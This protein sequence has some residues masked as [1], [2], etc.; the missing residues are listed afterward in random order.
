MIDEFTRWGGRLLQLL[1]AHSEQWGYYQLIHLEGTPLVHIDNRMVI[2]MFGGC[3]AAVLWA[4]N[5]KLR[6]PHSRIR[7][8]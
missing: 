8:V 2:G 4:S 5:V 7:I 1:D 6:F 3:L